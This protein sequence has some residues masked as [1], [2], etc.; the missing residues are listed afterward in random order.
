MTNNS[1]CW[2]SWTC[3]CSHTRGPPN[4]AQ[5]ADWEPT[6]L[7]RGPIAVVW[8]PYEFRRDG[9]VSHCGVDVF[10]MLKV[11]GRWLIGNAMWTV[12]PEACDEL[13]PRRGDRKSLVELQYP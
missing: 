13:K 3:P 6:V 2:N 10:N 9:K 4:R 8:A 11:D 5:F 1:A 7:I 12:E